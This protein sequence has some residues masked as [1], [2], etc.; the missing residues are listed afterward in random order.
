MA[1]VVGH[2]PSIQFRFLLSASLWRLYADDTLAAETWLFVQSRSRR[3]LA[4][5]VAAVL[6]RGAAS[7]Q[8]AAALGVVQRRRRH[9]RP[10]GAWCR[11][12]TVMVG[13]H[14]EDLDE[15][16]WRVVFD[17]VIVA[18]DLLCRSGSAALCD[19]CRCPDVQ[20]WLQYGL[21]DLLGHLA[22]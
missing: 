6:D 2:Y 14:F 19:I 4:A 7:A 12:H 15:A 16:P 10:T 8:S 5:A 3:W 13:L 20:C 21:H 17:E 11:F 18:V 9:A 22:G 1:L